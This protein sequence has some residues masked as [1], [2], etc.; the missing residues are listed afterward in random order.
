[1]ARLLQQDIAQ[2]LPTNCK[3]SSSFLSNIIW[4]RT[5]LQ[6][7]WDK[8]KC[9]K[10]NSRDPR[11]PQTRETL[12]S[13]S[14]YETWDLHNQRTPTHV[15]SVRYFLSEKFWTKWLIQFEATDMKTEALLAILAGYQIQALHMLSVIHM[16]QSNGKIIFHIIK[17]AK[18]SKQSRPN[19]PVVCMAYPENDLLCPVKCI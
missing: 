10:C 19:Q 1:M 16:D 12:V 13:V 7:Y 14:V 11:S 2:F 5:K 17:L 6:C 9:N 8:R 18:C 4:I 3:S 15:L